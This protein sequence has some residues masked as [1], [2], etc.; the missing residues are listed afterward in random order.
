M[1]EQV[2]DI[3]FSGTWIN[4]KYYQNLLLTKSP[5]ASQLYIWTGIANIPKNNTERISLFIQL[6]EG[7]DFKFIKEG[8]EYKFTDFYTDEINKD[9]WGI[10]ELI[11]DSVLQIGNDTLLFFSESYM[12]AYVLEKILFKGKYQ[13]GREEVSFTEEGGLIGFPDYTGYTVMIDYFLPGMQFD[14]L[15]M[16]KDNNE[17]ERVIFEFSED[18]LHLYAIN[19][20]KYNDENYC[21]NTDK[22]KKLYAL[23][24]IN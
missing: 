20:K 2:I 18:S 22:G 5:K 12:D 1:D 7:R 16:K 21:I 9:G 14:Q 11:K 4:Q 15:L 13:L 10:K 8:D 17:V 6:H 19:C 23:K 3:P 24:K